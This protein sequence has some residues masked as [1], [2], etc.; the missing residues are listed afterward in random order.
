VYSNL[1][2]LGSGKLE[3]LFDLALLP[4]VIPFHSTNT[5]KNKDATTQKEKEKDETPVLCQEQLLECAAYELSCFPLL[6][7]VRDLKLMVRGM[8]SVARVDLRQ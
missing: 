5:H 2:E 3:T 4:E 7:E 8:W 6:R 1:I